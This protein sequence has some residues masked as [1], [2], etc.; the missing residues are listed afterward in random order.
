MPVVTFTSGTTALVAKT[1]NKR[2][3]LYGGGAA[4]GGAT[5]NPAAGGGGSG[6]Q[7]SESRVK[8][9]PGNSYNVAVGAGVT[10]TTTT[11]VN[12]NDTTFTGTG[13]GGGTAQLASDDFNR[14][15]GPIGSNWTNMLGGAFNIDTGAAKF[16]SDQD[17]ATYYNAV[18]W[19]DDQY[20]EITFKGTDTPD[21]ADVGYGVL[22][23]QSASA[24]TCYRAVGSGTGWDVAKFITGS[25]TSLASGG[26]VTFANGDTLRLEVVGTTWTLKKNGSVVATDTDASI[27]SGNAGIAYS[28]PGVNNTT[29]DS[30]A[31]GSVG[32]SGSIN[33]TARG[34]IGAA[35]TTG[36]GTG[37]SGSTTGGVGDTVTAGGNGASATSTSAPGG[38]GGGGGGN[39]S[40]GTGGTATS[41]GGNG[42]NGGANNS[43]GGAGT[44]FGGG[45]GGGRA[46]NATD[47]AGGNG[48]AG[49]AIVDWIPPASN[50]LLGVG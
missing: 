6:G 10:G 31:G 37:A 25:Y 28:A 11:T 39:A 13:I 34:G 8:C 18:V 42:G 22:C 15:D 21:S 24:H 27:A 2:V 30:W 9:V 49:G 14:A 4:G 17:C 7:K 23:R 1:T 38:G 33:V 26:A 50:L 44:A 29:I 40:G 41:P 16:N 35:T 36:T 46:G 5:G 48:A 32:G 19:P 43:Q 20:S 3:R 45:G 47:R 12:G